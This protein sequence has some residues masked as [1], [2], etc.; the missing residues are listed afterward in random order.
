[1]PDYAT[2][3]GRPQMPTARLARRVPPLP[4][5]ARKGRIVFLN[6]AS[7]SGKSSIARAL[8]GLLAE[9]YLHLELD[10]FFRMLPRRLLGAA[11]HRD[12]GIDLSGIISGFDRS[13][14]AL[15]AAGNNLIVDHVLERRETLDRCLWL[16][17]DFWVLFVG[18]RCPA[19]ELQR[20]ERSRNRMKGLASL[21]L[22][23]VH[24]HGVY[25]LE[26]DTSLRNP[27]ECAAEIVAALRGSPPSAFHRLRTMTDGG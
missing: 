13:I 6:G 7:S 20:R 22:P 24:A 17:E 9:P 26:V 19:E 25:D 27:V 12:A 23:C 2:S 16:L 14:A 15:A 4:E 1:M 11:E 18:V 8:Q 5:P 10:Q 3:P 21:Q